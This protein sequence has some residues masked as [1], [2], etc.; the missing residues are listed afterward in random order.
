VRFVKLECIKKP[1]KKG[2]KKGGRKDGRKD[3]R[4]KDYPSFCAY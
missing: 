4:K 2:G 3:G 1:C